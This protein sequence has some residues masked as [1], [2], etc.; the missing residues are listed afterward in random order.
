MHLDIRF[1]SRSYTCSVTEALQKM[2]HLEEYWGDLK[3]PNIDV[4]PPYHIY[5]T[6]ANITSSVYAEKWCLS[7]FHLQVEFGLVGN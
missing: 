6:I 4:Y 5:N 3:S 7:L 1:Y 2:F